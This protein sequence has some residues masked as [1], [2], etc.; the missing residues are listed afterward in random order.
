MSNSGGDVEHRA[1]HR[2]WADPVGFDS[3]CETT[4]RKM[5]N[6]YNMV[7]LRVRSMFRVT[8]RAMFKDHSETLR[9]RILSLFASFCGKEFA[10]ISQKRTYKTPIHPREQ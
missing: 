2:A 6:I 10:N 8:T 7:T 9:V 5:M 4:P 1:A 3:F